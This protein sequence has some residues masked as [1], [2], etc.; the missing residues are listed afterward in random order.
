MDIEGSYRKLLKRLAANI[1]K[2]R[3]ARGL[4]QEEMATYGINYRH[5]QK[6]ESGRYS[7]NLYTLHR[8]AKIFRVSIREFLS[9]VD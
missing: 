4:T 7:P 5:Y 6:I 8:L 3:K 1:K 9:K 2:A